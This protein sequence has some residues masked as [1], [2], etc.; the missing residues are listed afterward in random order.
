MRRLVHLLA[1]VGTVTVVVVIIGAMVGY[2]AVRRGFSARAAPSRL[3]E[4]L[5]QS[6]RSWATPA[7]MREAKNPLAATRDVLGEARAHW[8][9][10]CAVCHANDG[11]GNTQIGR[12]LY[13][14][15]PDMRT[16]RTQ[17]L[18]DGE[19]YSVIENG[20]RL[21]G[22]PAWGTSDTMGS[23]ESW[24]LVAFIR[25]LPRLSEKELQEMH[26]LNPKGAH[27]RG[28]DQEEQDFLNKG[29]HR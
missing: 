5:A 18:T 1:A 25:H 10:H 22:M 28:E 4:W 19:L 17:R 27:E 11:S 20:V 13:P 7:K 8:A 15:A 9:D 21:T 3:E 12:N 26:R 29:E 14:R 23:K 6:M 16:D 24:A 2:A